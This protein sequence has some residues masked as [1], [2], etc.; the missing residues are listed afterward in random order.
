[1]AMAPPDPPSPT[2]DGDHRHS[3]REAFL[4]RSRDGFSLT[5]LLRL[6]AG[7]G[8]RRIDQRDDR[9][10]EPVGEAHQ[11]DGL[12]IALRLGHAEIVLEPRSGVVAFLMTDQHHAAPVDAREA[13]DDRG[14][15]GEGAITRQ[16]QEILREPRH[17]ILEVR[18][19]RVTRDLRL[20]PRRQ[21]GVGVAQQLVRLGLEPADFGVDIDRPSCSR[22]RAARRRESPARRSV[23]RNRG[24]SALE[25]GG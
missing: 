4:G 16:R 17:I 14:I 7:K 13:A 10:A 11:S 24:K 8:A 20:L 15:V 2:I 22:F 12:P 21:L 23:F 1:M 19:F 3:E 9:N 18:A 5:P 25:R 6:H